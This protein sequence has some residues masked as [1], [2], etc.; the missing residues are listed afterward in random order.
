MVEKIFNTKLIGKVTTW[1]LGKD[2]TAVASWITAGAVIGSGYFFYE[3][4]YI[5]NRNEDR[6]LH[7]R[8]SQEH[9]K[10]VAEV[11]A[12]AESQGKACDQDKERLFKANEALMNRI[13]TMLERRVVWPQ[14][15]SL[16]GVVG[17]SGIEFDCDP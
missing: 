7:L 5:P 8:V 16:N 6:A 2:S 15:P 14:E 3:R 9:V 11:R 4:I 10:A 17:S 1:I 13:D 12:M